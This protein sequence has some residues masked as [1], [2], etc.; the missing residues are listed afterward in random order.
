LSLQSAHW[1]YAIGKRIAEGVPFN[2]HLF[3]A[4]NSESYEKGG[5]AGEMSTYERVQVLPAASS[6]HF[7]SLRLLSSVF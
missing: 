1:S 7:L 4:S 3:D 5:V 2:V 6:A